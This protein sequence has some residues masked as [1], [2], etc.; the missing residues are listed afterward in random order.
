MESI[1]DKV[2]VVGMGCCK[3]GE[4]WDK[5][6][7]DLIVEAAYEAYEDAG[8]EPKDIQA[9]WV[10]TNTSGRAGFCL[11]NA[12][13]LKDLPITRVENYC[14]TGMDAFRNAVFGV[15]SG[16]YDT[17]L[18][19]GF[20][21]LKDL[22]TGGL[23]GQTG[24]E[25]VFRPA[26]MAPAGTPG[27]YFGM[28][29][30]VYFKKY[31]ATREH[32][33][34]IAV[35]NHHNGTLAPKAHFQREITMEQALNAPM[36]AWPL[37]LFDCCGVTDGAAAAIITRRELAKDFR[38]DYVLVKGLGLSV[39]SVAH[40]WR[41]G[42]DYVHWPASVNAAK[43][44]YRH[45][46]ITDPFKQIDLAGIHDCFTI[47]E[48]LAYEDLGFCKPGE[49]KDH[50]DSGTFTLQ[51]ELPVNTDGGLKAF[52]HP[53]GATG[54]RMIYEIYKQVQGKAGA[55]QVKDA[56]IG[57]AHNLGGHP[58]VSSVAILGR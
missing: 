15:A 22:G 56:H 53:V 26:V 18:A 44:A 46:G 39:D 43:E 45:A 4:N 52:G 29:A 5:G 31:G 13:K 35:K 25:L 11:A 12:L 21:K 17:V 16:M 34:K 37:G 24:L 50:V 14:C 6:A 38:Q 2:A 3:F 58:S 55:R 36:I 30:N 33:A 57:L 23:V 9:A 42:H 32:L 1:R 7:Q 40:M 8:I 48:L 27:S 47:T 19:L 51:G 49:A 41:N 28:A 20:D 54:L 10:G